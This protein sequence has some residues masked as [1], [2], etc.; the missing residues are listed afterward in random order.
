MGK[1]KIRFILLAIRFIR[2]YYYKYFFSYMETRWI[3]KRERDY[4]FSTWQR[5]NATAEDNLIPN[6]KNF[7]KIP[8][9]TTV[10]VN[11]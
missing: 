3:Y 4:I 11:S 1:D 6:K 5:I 7:K 10:N 2:K 9:S 8:K